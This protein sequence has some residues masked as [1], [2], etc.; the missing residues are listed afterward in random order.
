MMTKNQGQAL[1][2]FVAEMRTD[3]DV[4]GILAQVAKVNQL[5]SYEVAHALL[6]LAE[7]PAVKNPGALT[8]TTGEHWREKSRNASSSHP[9]RRNETCPAHPAY[10]R[11]N[12]GG[13]RADELAG[14][15][16]PPTRP[17]PGDAATGLAACRETLRGGGA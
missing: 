1:A 3:W 14:E 10:H 4:P 16:V 13:C 5:N 15:R 9:P 7:N 11:D 17:R 6:R 8:V 12:C 2:V